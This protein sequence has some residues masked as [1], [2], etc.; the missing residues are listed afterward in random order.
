MDS[1]HTFRTEP[2]AGDVEAVRSLVANTGFFRPDEVAVA[3]ELVEERLAEGIASDYYF[4]LADD[5][6]GMLAG[7]VCFGPIPC[8]VGSFDLY[9]IAVDKGQQGAGLGRQLVRQAEDAA[10]GMGGRKMYIETSG[11]PLYEPTRRFY[12]RCG[13][14]EEAR[15]VDFYDRDDDKLIVS[16]VL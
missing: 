14:V 15:L 1:A 8:T 12:S 6:R 3:G 11:Q 9:W 10:K 7:Y 13:Y 4:S 2:R 16:K 5:E